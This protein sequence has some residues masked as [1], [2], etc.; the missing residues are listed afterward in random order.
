MWTSVN[1]KRPDEKAR[2]EAWRAFSKRH[3][4]NAP[5]Y[6]PQH[7]TNRREPFQP[8]SWRG[9]EAPMVTKRKG[10]VLPPMT[11]PSFIQK[12]L[13]P[14]AD[15]KNI[16]AL[17]QYHSQP[18]INDLPRSTVFSIQSAAPSVTLAGV[19]ST[20][21]V[22]ATSDNKFFNPAT[23]QWVD[24]MLLNP[25]TGAP[26]DYARDEIPTVQTAIVNPLMTI[27][28]VLA[29]LNILQQT[30]SSISAGSAN[31]ASLYTQYQSKLGTPT[32]VYARV[33]GTSDVLAQRYTELKAKNTTN[34][35]TNPGSSSGPGGG[36]QP[37][38]QQQ[39]WWQWA[40]QTASNPWIQL[41]TSLISRYML[42]FPLPIKIQFGNGMTQTGAGPQADARYIKDLK[43]YYLEMANWIAANLWNMVSVSSIL[44]IMSMVITRTYGAEHGKAIDIL[45]SELGEATTPDS[46]PTDVPVPANVPLPPKPIQQPTTPAGWTPLLPPQQ[47]QTP[48]PPQQPQTPAPST[49]PFPQ[50]WADQYASTAPIILYSINNPLPYSN[51]TFTF[52][53]LATPDNQVALAY[54][55]LSKPPR[56]YDTPSDS[57]IS[58]LKPFDLE[59]LSAPNNQVALTYDNLLRNDPSH[60]TVP[61]L[62]ETTP[63]ISKLPDGRSV[64]LPP[65]HPSFTPDT[66]ITDLLPDFTIPTLFE[67]SDKMVKTISKA[68]NISKEEIQ[69]WK[70][71][72]QGLPKET[73]LQLR[74]AGVG[75]V[76]V[77]T[78]MGLRKLMSTLDRLDKEARDAAFTNANDNDDDDSPDDSP[79]DKPPGDAKEGPGWEEKVGEDTSPTR[80]LHPVLQSVLDNT[81]ADLAAY[82]PSLEGLDLIQP[83]RLGEYL[84]LTQNIEDTIADGG[85]P[86][87]T[88][89][90]FHRDFFADHLTPVYLGQ[91]ERVEYITPPVSPSIKGDYDTVDDEMEPLQLNEIPLQEL[92]DAY[93]EETEDYKGQF[94]R[95]VNEMDRPDYK[96]SEEKGAELRRITDEL[97]T[98]YRVIE[99]WMEDEPQVNERKRPRW[100]HNTQEFRDAYQEEAQEYRDQYERLLRKINR[101]GYTVS[102]K[103]AAKLNRLAKEIEKRYGVMLRWMEDEKRASEI[104]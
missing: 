90:K 78:A 83:N 72:V 18:T 74:G 64:T 50:S 30:L 7:E 23:Q 104:N 61:P 96:G 60:T 86:D 33:K 54:P 24:G 70:I 4:P 35:N 47:P 88:D 9:Y 59:P 101:P 99:S 6:E 76:A 38:P 37:T 13:R 22:R 49:W 40:G 36:P 79:D 103:Q 26:W 17:T 11:P 100:G 77:V 42:G 82:L 41:V 57:V 51:N 48:V 44:S 1:T 16:A 32:D 89:I 31:L 46:M 73:L 71:V 15:H 98:R 102:R 29:T 43:V 75:A 69:K 62:E 3:K 93:R 81:E 8:L 58:P 85:L 25:V 28:A 80:W 94:E 5:A 55:P 52:P 84:E 2:D 91:N 14:R 20:N 53:P 10:R 92:R 21:P 66:K 87:S 67:I 65:L 56:I 34:P 12:A 27:D 19:S 97:A 95:L 39:S 68:Y 45:I 63:V